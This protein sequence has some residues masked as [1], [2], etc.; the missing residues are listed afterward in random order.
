MYTALAKLDAILA[1]TKARLNAL[2]RA[3]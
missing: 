1:A 3:R 2:Q